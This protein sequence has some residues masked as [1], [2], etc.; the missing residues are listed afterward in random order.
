MAGFS[1]LINTNKRGITFLLLVL[2]V[3]FLAVSYLLNQEL[4]SQTRLTTHQQAGVSYVGVIR[5]LLEQLQQHR[6]LSNAHLNGEQQVQKLPRLAKDIDNTTRH[7][8]ELYLDLSNAPR[9]TER[10]AN[11][12]AEWRSLKEQNLSLGADENFDTHSNLIDTLLNTLQ[13][14]ADAFRLTLNAKPDNHYLTRALLH[15]PQ[16]MEAIE[17]TRRLGSAIIQRGVISDQERLRITALGQAISTA[18]DELSLIMNLLFE[19]HP[20][21][22]ISLAPLLERGDN[23]TGSFLLD[24]YTYLL[25]SA[26]P[27][28]AGPAYLNAST[29]AL[30]NILNL[31]DGTRQ[32]LIQLHAKRLTDIQRKQALLIL[33]TLLA[34]AIGLIFYSL[35]LRHQSAG[36][37][38]RDRL[39]NSVMALTESN[40]TLQARE[41]ELTHINHKLNQFTYVAS[42]DLKA[43]LRAI[44]NLSQWIEEDLE[45]TMNEDSR[46][47]MD[48]LRTRVKRMEALI[49]G[50]LQYSRLG[51]VSKKNEVFAVN[52]MLNEILDGLNCPPGFRIDIATDMPTVKT[53]RVP[54]SQIFSNLLSNAIKYHEHPESGQI[55]ISARPL[56]N[57][58]YEFS[59]ADNGPGIAP[60]YHE[61]IFQI[62]QTLNPRDEIESTGIGLTIVQNLVEQLGGKIHLDSAEGQGST[63]RF[64][65]PKLDSGEQQL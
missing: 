19:H 51:H 4:T 54:L 29:T 31:F 44:A 50:I 21:I 11:W 12:E 47:N 36:K 38:L 16:Q 13:G 59:V 41:N 22:K 6:V 26:V 9:L 18:M 23:S 48:L 49:N 33:S 5:T 7:I 37:Q 24:M 40:Q 52:D 45:G 2:I 32:Q 53:A 15:L 65:L 1:D 3:P 20:E 55:S 34:L 17:Q 57:T 8:G 27:N 63:F 61:K 46:K 30:Q 35:V 43:P 39:Q 25:E 58:E 28:T 14:T 64:T 62:F 10:W 56:N 60:Q 42:H